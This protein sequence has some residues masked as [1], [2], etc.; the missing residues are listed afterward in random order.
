MRP[1]MLRNLIL[2]LALMVW[3]I[4]SQIAYAQADPVHLSMG[5][6]S[7][8]DTSDTPDGSVG[9]PR[10]VAVGET[11][12][13]R[14]VSV[15]PESTTISFELYDVIVA[16]LSLVPSSVYVSYQADV[17]PSMN[18]DFAGIQNQANPT[19]LFPANGM[20]YNGGTGELTLD[21]G[22]IINNDGDSGEE[23][24]IVEFDVVVVDVAENEADVVFVNEYRLTIDEG[25]PTQ[26]IYASN[27]VSVI[28]VEPWLETTAVFAPDQ[29]VRGATTTL[30]VVVNNLASNGATGPLQDVVVTHNFDDRL[31]IT[32]MGVAF[33][34]AAT[35]F[36][37]SFIN[38]SVVTGGFSA[39]VT[40]N[41][42]VHVS[43][44]PVDGVATITVTLQIDPNFDP[45]LLSSTLTSTM[46]VSADSLASDITPDDNDRSHSDSASDDLNIVKPTLLATLVE[47]NDPVV[48]GSEVIYTFS[49][50]NTGTPAI[51]ATDVEMVMVAPANFVVTEAASA[52]GSCENISTT[53]SVCSGSII[54]GESALMTMRG[55]YS[56]S[57]SSGAIGNVIA[58]VTSAEGNHGNDGND[59]PSDG[60][61]ERAE[62]PTTIL[63]QV[64]VGLTKTVDNPE[65][66][67]G[68]TAT[69]TL[70]LANN[71]PSDASN[72]IVTDSIP[73]GLTFVQF[74][75]VDLPCVYAAPSVTCVLS[76]LASGATETITLQ[77]SVDAGI[78]GVPITNT[79]SVTTTEPETNLANNSDDAVL[80]VYHAVSLSVDNTTI[81]E[82]GGS[83]VITATLDTANTT[84]A[85]I[86]IP[87]VVNVAST[88]S[89]PDDFTLSASTITIANGASSGFVTL[90][91]VS[92]V[93]PEP[94]ETILIEL[95]TLPTHVKVGAVSTV[96][97]TIPISD[98]VDA[99]ALLNGSF[100]TAG[101]SPQ[102]AQSWKL[103]KTT[104]DNVTR[105]CKNASDGLCA[106]RFKQPKVIIG[107]SKAK[108]TQ[109]IL[110]PAVS[111]GDILTLS[112]W[113][114]ANRVIN[115]GRII[116]RV[117]Y[118]DG[119]EQKSTLVIAAGTY[120]YTE[121]TGEITLS[122]VPTKILVV[123]R[124][125]HVIGTFFVDDVTL[126]RT[127]GSVRAEMLPLP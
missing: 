88:A 80:T 32:A 30:S 3:F 97:I 34:T 103:S 108:V 85:S 66:I 127:L 124:P 86:E 105:V 79:A 25:L 125:D 21:F 119:S 16:G 89:T 20:T 62:E 63:R 106:L 23:F 120:D 76:T 110:S 38:N 123:L 37:S 55:Y 49:V 9:N 27:E 14:L 78:A 1:F 113:V 46:S 75:P 109:V 83:A 64:D 81:D 4:P 67:A 99:L 26:E 98:N 122:G 115:Q 5:G 44:L 18:G 50:V 7:E 15:L 100:E 74:L 24:I 29:A 71:G 43:G 69:F 116:L 33:N 96:T 31:N 61:D 28:V 40:D 65:P 41:L 54:M 42:N 22:S 107:P 51:S 101:N 11:I 82:E 13:Y 73:A 48:A 56:A 112:A 121:V 6:T 104:V 35:D 47:N 72:I 39:G 94:D 12:T 19:F 117:M 92:D 95:G 70:Q 2:L 126:L 53:M 8:T 118:S 91:G 84:G 57:T 59:T 77:A 17:L 52:I 102:R 36:G 114:K 10:P 87:V 58:Y 111:A 93:L 45:L 60:D 68:Q 90:N